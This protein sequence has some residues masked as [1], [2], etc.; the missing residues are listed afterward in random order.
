LNDNPSGQWKLRVPFFP[1]NRSAPTL[2]GLLLKRTSWAALALFFS[3][4][5]TNEWIG[6]PE[7]DLAT[8]TQS[9]LV[10]AARFNRDLDR[11]QGIL[12]QAN[13]NIVDHLVENTNYAPGQLAQARISLLAALSDAENESLSRETASSQFD[14]IHTRSDSWFS[15]SRAILSR[16]AAP[17]TTVHLDDPDVVT[18]S[19]MLDSLQGLCADLRLTEDTLLATEVGHN[20][21]PSIALRLSLEFLLFVLLCT[22]Y[23][24]RELSAQRKVADLQASLQENAAYRTL[25]DDLPLPVLLF[26]ESG[27][28]ILSA[29]R[30][31]EAKY[32]YE[33][34][35]LQQLTL[36]ALRDPSESARSLEW[37]ATSDYRVGEPLDGGKWTHRRKDGT[38]FTVWTHV[39]RATMGERSVALL[40]VTDVSGRESREAVLEEVN[41]TLAGVLDSLPLSIAWKDRSLK[42]MGGNRAF[43]Q[44][45]GHDD[46]GPLADASLAGAVLD[47]RS[48]VNDE[49]VLEGLIA[50]RNVEEVHPV[51]ADLW[52]SRSQLPLRSATGEIVGVVDAFEDIT[53]RKRRELAMRLRLRALDASVNAILIV[54][55]TPKG[56]V[57]E[58]T[59]PAFARM[60]GYSTREAVDRD[61]D[62]LHA[63]D[64]EQ[65]GVEQVATAMREGVEVAAVMRNYR[66]D[67][68]SFWCKLYV[69]P[70]RE[71]G[72]SPTHYVG[73]LTD[74]TELIQYQEQLERQANFDTLTQLPNRSLL[75]TR[76]VAA[77]QSARANRTSVAVLF[78]DLDLFKHVNDSLGHGVGDRLLQHISERLVACVR[79][80]DTVARYGGDEFVMILPHP[81]GVDLPA[82]LTRIL[83][84]I[85][86]PVFVNEHELYVEASI[87]VSCYPGDG[88][89]PESLLKKADAAMYLAKER[90]RNSFEFYHTELDAEVNERLAISNSLR[91]AVRAGELEVHYQPQVDMRT[92]RILGAEALLRWNDPELGMVPPSTFIPLAE[93]SGLIVKMG[94]FVLREAC[95]QLVAWK[96][97]GLPMLR[98]SVNLSPQ[99]LA[100]SNVLSMVETVLVET[101]ASPTHLE[102]EMTEST[103]MSNVQETA[104]LLNSLQELG[105]HIAIDDFGT[106][107]SSLSYLKKFKV[108]RIKI[109]RAFVRDI[110]QDGDDEIITRA[111]IALASTLD[112]QVIAEGVETERQRDFLLRHGCAEGQGFLYSPAVNPE[113]FALKLRQ[114]G[115]TALA[116][117]QEA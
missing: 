90:G 25:F 56:N 68:S 97:Q 38:R 10:K 40:V 59:N 99:Q 47:A 89:T 92:G 26:E 67:G 85:S 84:A 73:V 12:A 32:G 19:G 8:R 112:I 102:L 28:V 42:H 70:I 44:N 81:E 115:V 9:L 57:I 35:E 96:A 15:A 107:Y 48:S 1:D 37:W 2:K 75:Q 43:V 95:K 79:D 58:Y 65:R 5:T 20:P 39:V 54:R 74:V 106:G 94:E 46:S 93:E 61:F 103:L 72:G 27:Q 63:D 66:K 64:T 33:L 78:L 51:N 91:R 98:M 117:M 7:Q 55:A 101:G 29:N 83:A 88:D 49:K 104:R 111:V 36:S 6:S 50:L 86:E 21:T 108:D 71:L 13:Q 105:L 23:A 16:A 113:V 3:V 69:A 76:L 80:T 17:Q 34:E 100:R 24:S 31:A 18:A 114:G 110:G 60:T 82:L 45:T 30:A 41:A 53:L 22:A 14:E 52:I 11:V 4:T 77:I 116:S 62:F 109:D 87:G